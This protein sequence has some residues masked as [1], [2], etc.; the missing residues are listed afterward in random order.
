LRWYRRA[1]EVWADSRCGWTNSATLSLSDRAD[2]LGDL[3]DQLISQLTS[4]AVPEEPRPQRSLHIPAGVLQRLLADYP[5]LL[6]GY[7][8]SRTDPRRFILV[9]REAP[10]SAGEDAAGR[11]SLD[12]LFVDQDVGAG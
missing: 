6:A 1:R 3:A 4:P 8:M 9:S 5:Q 10:V 11:W 7:Q 2:H 12:H